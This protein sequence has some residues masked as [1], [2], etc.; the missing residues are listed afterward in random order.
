MGV[1]DVVIAEDEELIR[2]AFRSLISSFNGFRVVADV[3]DGRGAVEA[4]ERTK[5]HVILMDLFM[6]RMDGI[7]A[8]RDIKKRLPGVK[9]LALTAQSGDAQIYSALAAG[10]DG[11]VLKNVS[12]EELFQAMHAV[13]QDRKYMCGGLME[14][15]VDGYVKGF[16][17]RPPE[18]LADLSR[19][20]Y[21]ILELISKGR[22][23]KQIAA[24]LGISIK[25]VEKHRA[26]L[27]RKLGV[28]STAELVA[29]FLLRETPGT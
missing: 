11:Y 29:R 25:T 13:L 23:N 15:V 2:E 28:D 19:R 3:G 12:R 5:P 18:D 21:Q 10:V 9:I 22:L 1:I 6:P 17:N 27:K 26:S 4:A 7:T 24:E 8:T 20:E 16:E 14:Q